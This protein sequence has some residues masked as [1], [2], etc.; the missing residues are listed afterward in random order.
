MKNAIVLAAIMF[1]FFVIA[2]ST[3]KNYIKKTV[4]Q[5]PTTSGAVTEDEKLTSINYL[6][7]LGRSI[8]LISMQA[9]GNRENIINYSEYDYSGTPS[10]KYLPLAAGGAFSFDSSRAVLNM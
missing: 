7:G 1:P 10:R 3:D 8:E 6:D 5:I 2:Q 9:G 4:Y